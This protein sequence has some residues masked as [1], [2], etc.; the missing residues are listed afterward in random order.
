MNG[1]IGYFLSVQQDG[2]R[3]WSDKTGNGIERGSFPGAVWSKKTDDNSGV[4]LETYSV[5]H[6]SAAVPFNDVPCFKK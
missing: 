3:A 1:E 6:G 2:S 5:H 4:D